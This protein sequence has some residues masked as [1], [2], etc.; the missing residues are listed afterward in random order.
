[1]QFLVSGGAR[2]WGWEEQ[3]SDG[4]WEGSH[5]D[6]SLWDRSLN[7]SEYVGKSRLGCHGSDAPASKRDGKTP[8]LELGVTLP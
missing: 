4:K 3:G 8:K 6:C 5:R 7:D 2:H 1:M